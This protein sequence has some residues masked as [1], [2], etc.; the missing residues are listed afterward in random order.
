MGTGTVPYQ[1]T[2]K[3]NGAEVLL[4]ISA[5]PQYQRKS[6]D[7]LRWGDYASKNG[8]G[9]AGATTTN[10]AVGGMFGAAGNTGAFGAAS[11]TTSGFGGATNRN[12]MFG[13]AKTT[14]GFGGGNAFGNTNNN[15]MFGN[16]KTNN[17]ATG[18]MFG[19][20]KTTTGFGGG[21]AFGAANN[22]ATGM[23]RP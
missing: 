1:P 3:N 11:N 15:T 21:N 2:N 13:A 17:T 12:G 14:T 23:Q 5:M 18:G 4:S 10:T 19:G 22:T 8:A 16:A 7:E 9:V 6:A 20:A